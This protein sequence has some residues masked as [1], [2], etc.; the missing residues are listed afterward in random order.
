MIVLDTNVISELFKPS[1]ASSTLRWLQEQPGDAIY[2][3]AITRGELLFGL[4]ILPEGQRKNALLGGLLRIFEVRFPARVLAYDSEAA[5]AHA[6]IAAERRASGR[7]IAQSDAMI[8]GIVRSR[9][10]RLATRNV[11]DFEDCGIALIDPWH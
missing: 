9:N 3:T 11:R 8:A 4:N 6:A 1:P 10:A 5:D 2:T 7:P